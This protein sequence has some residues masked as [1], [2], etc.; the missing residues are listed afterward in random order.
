MTM[1]ALKFGAL[2]LAALFL[3][4][5]SDDHEFDNC[6][7]NPIPPNYGPVSLVSLSDAE[8]ELGNIAS[9]LALTDISSGAPD[10]TAVGSP[11]ARA[12]GPGHAPV[13]AFSSATQPR[14]LA[15][16]V[17]QTAVSTCASGSDQ[18]SSGSKSR[19]FS[20]F[21]FSGSVNY[22]LDSYHRCA[23]TSNGTT[24]TLDGLLE[25]GGTAD[26][27]YNY[28]LLGD[29]NAGNTITVFTD[30]NDAN[31]TPLHT[32]LDLFG[33]IESQSSSTSLD[34]RSNLF[35][36]LFAS[37]PQGSYDGSFQIGNN[38]SVYDVI[39][40]S[41][42]LSVAGPYA[43]ASTVCTGG[44]VTVTT[45]TTLVLGTTSAGSGLP[46]GGVLTISTGSNNS[47]VS[48]SFNSDGS[49][50]LTGSISGTISAAT[51]GSLLQNGTSC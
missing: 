40:S 34:T 9:T 8:R 23:N 25:T 45:P 42:S 3:A 5:C 13:R 36:T 26:G 20:N 19:T 27:V 14:T 32:E 41:T 49:A 33:P 39:G 10:G 11:G 46:V 51:V 22:S 29:L 16:A 4:G 28:A 43:Y 47:S 38:S 48:Y 50:T 37:Q 12:L 21:S 24:T 31:G 2:G 30:G 1:Q 7:F 44:A 17:P 18:V 35:A 6:C 15:V